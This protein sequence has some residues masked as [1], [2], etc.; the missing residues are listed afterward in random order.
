LGD[1]LAAVFQGILEN[2]FIKSRKKAEKKLANAGS[3][4]IEQIIG[5]RIFLLC[6][7]IPL[8]ILMI[9][10]ATMK[11]SIRQLC[12][13][14]CLLAIF[15]IPCFFAYFYFK[16]DHYIVSEENIVHHRLFGKSKT[17]EYSDIFYILYRNKGDSLTAYNKYGTILF[18]IGDMHIGIERLTDILEEKG[19]RRERTELITEDMKNSEE[20]GQNQEKN[21]RVNIIILA[22]TF[23][24]MAGIVLLGLYL[25]R[26]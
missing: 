26:K 7:L 22:V 16:L 2:T 10:I 17:I 11:I 15:V 3:F 18:S 21:K 5:I 24:V 9:W 20:Y 6:F 8:V 4:K 19:I 23:I 12:F 25:G 1:F 13:F 14:E